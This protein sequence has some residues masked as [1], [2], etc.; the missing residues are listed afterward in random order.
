MLIFHCSPRSH[1]IT[2]KIRISKLLSINVNITCRL[3]LIYHDFCKGFEATV[4]TAYGYK[5]F[6]ANVKAKFYVDRFSI[7][8]IVRRHL[9][10]TYIHFNGDLGLTPR[11]NIISDKLIVSQTFSKFLYVQFNFYALFTETSN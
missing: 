9:G 4:G 7:Y 6:E 11:K 3:I 2:W 5:E 8:K 1:F 10:P